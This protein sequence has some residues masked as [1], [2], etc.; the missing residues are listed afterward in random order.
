VFRAGASLFTIR[1][2]TRNHVV[3]AVAGG[4][5]IAVAG[6]VGQIVV[7]A[8]ALATIERFDVSTDPLVASVYV[9]GNEIASLRPGAR[10][11]MSVQ[12]AP[13]REFGLLEGTVAVLSRFPQ[14]RDQVSGFLSDDRLG[15]RF[16]SDT[17]PWQ[18]LVRLIPANTASGFSWTTDEGPPYQLDSRA[19]V[20]AQFHLA[21][22]RPIA[23]LTAR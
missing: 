19:L 15:A 17:Q 7:A 3:R 1:T 5:A 23:W 21:P 13:A 22:I 2:D 9:A 10:V 4:R 11:T 8:D 20:E 14:S 6:K 16:A 18:V 12:S